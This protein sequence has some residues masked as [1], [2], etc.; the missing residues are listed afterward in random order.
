MTRDIQSSG[1]SLL[2]RY[3]WVVRRA[4]HARDEMDIHMHRPKMRYVSNEGGLTKLGVTPGGGVPA[5]PASAASIS[6]GVRA[7][8]IVK[9]AGGRLKCRGLPWNKVKR[10]STDGKLQHIRPEEVESAEARDQRSLPSDGKRSTWSWTPKDRSAQNYCKRKSRSV[11][12]LHP[13]GWKTHPSHRICA[14]PVS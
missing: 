6:A 2:S 1:C 7:C 14:C 3:H 4:A 13:V 8:A 9:T 10:K 5:G 11:R 12:A